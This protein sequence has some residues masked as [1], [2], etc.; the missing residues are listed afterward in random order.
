MTS[1]TDHCTFV[2]NKAQS[3]NQWSLEV[4][5]G[6]CFINKHKDSQKQN[7]SYLSLNLLID[8]SNPSHFRNF[9]LHP[10]LQQKQ[11]CIFTGTSDRD[12]FWCLN[13]E[14]CCRPQRRLRGIPPRS[15]SPCKIPWHFTH[16]QERTRFLFVKTVF[17]A[18]L[19]PSNKSV[20]TCD[21]WFSHS[22]LYQAGLLLALCS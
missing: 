2:P 17:S 13:A 16:N 19:S 14:N 22:P 4:T 3:L 10:T 12:H 6:H 1:A 5:M 15:Y 7:C 9:Q 21:G 20:C 11:N 18:A 8:T